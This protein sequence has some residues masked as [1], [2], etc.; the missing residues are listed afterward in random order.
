MSSF[1]YLAGSRF[2]LYK[3]GTVSVSPTAATGYG[4]SF[5]Y[6]DDPSSP[7]IAGSVAADSYMRVDVLPF[8]SGGLQVSSFEFSTLLG[9]TS[10]SL[11][12]GTSAETTTAGEFRTGTKALKLTGT[13]SSNYGSRYFDLTVNSGEYRQA[14]VYM[15]SSASGTGKLF[16]RNLKTGNYYN[17]SAWAST[18][19]SAAS[20]TS[21]TAFASV[22]ATVV[23][24]QM[25]SF[26]A[27]R[28]DTVTL[29]WELVCDSGSFCFDDCL[30]VPGVN[31]ASIHGHNYGAVIPEVRYSTGDFITDDTLAATMTVK[32][33]AFYST[34]TMTYARYWQ[35]KLSG[36]NFEAPYTGEAVLGQSVTAATP[37]LSGPL[38]D[39]DIPGSRS[40]GTIG[41]MS[42]YSY[43][44][45]PRE[46]IRM[47][48]SA[49]SL[50]DA[51]NTADQLWLR[52]SQ[53]QYPV[54]VVPIDTEDFVYY[55]HVTHPFSMSRPN[56]DIYDYGIDVIGSPFPT[57]GL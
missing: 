48:F 15:R 10:G 33:P 18:R 16:L 3:R 56:V 37:L 2:N 50:D 28:A 24:Y 26:E 25:E 55:G 30:D 40:E 13:D 41:R 44:T 57:I 5:L 21:T 45:D 34:F 8:R 6:D 43:A 9:W 20:S 1:L 47:V 38:T 46:S 31:F 17:G 54:I 52:S 35:I 51:D 11:G 36:T 14:T 19:A 22:P 29:R 42:A 27:C 53:G 39:R 23:T 32:R 7:H 12:T 4:A 49:D